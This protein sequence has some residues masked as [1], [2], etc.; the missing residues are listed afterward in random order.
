M[1]TMEICAS[2]IRSDL[3]LL[4]WHLSDFSDADALVRPCAGANHANWQVGHTLA[5]TASMLT[6]IDS[7]FSA[8]MA[9]GF[10]EKYTKEASKSDDPKHFA[11][12]DDLRK[13]IEEVSAAAH[14]CV[15]KLPAEKLEAKSPDWANDFAPTIG[16]FL[17]F[18][19]SHVQMHI[20]QIQVIRRR[21]GKPVL[22]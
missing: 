7:G 1:T 19:A 13:G 14:A 8:P 4:K 17:P 20:G 21:L 2:H 16:L 3:G 10:G 18:I 11:T 22:F 15:S 5:S 12:L 9:K 6:F